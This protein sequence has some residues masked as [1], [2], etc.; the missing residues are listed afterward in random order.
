MILK[1]NPISNEMMKKL[2][3]A[4]NSRNKVIKRIRTKTNINLEKTTINK[5]SETHKRLNQEVYDCSS[6]KT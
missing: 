5:K 6:V 1:I 4:I 3:S 2:F